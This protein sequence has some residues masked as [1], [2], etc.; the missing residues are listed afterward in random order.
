[1]LGNNDWIG[2][3]HQGASVAW[4][5]VIR[6][7]WTGDNSSGSLTLD[8]VSAGE[9]EV[10]AFFNNSYIVEASSQLRVG[11]ASVSTNKVNYQS[12]EKIYVH[13]ANMLGNQDWI[14]IYHQGA[15][16][17]WNNVIRWSWTGDTS[18]GDL[19]FRGLSSGNYEVRAFFNNSYEIEAKSNFTVVT[20]QFDSIR[21]LILDSK[22]GLVN[23]AT[24]IC[25]GDSTRAIS[26]HEGQ[27]LFFE[28]RDKLN[29]YN[30]NSIL[31]ARRGHRARQFL[32]QS[33][34]PT[35]SEVVANIPGDGDHAIVDISLGINDIWAYG[36]SPIKSDLK[37][38]ILN[39]KAQKPLTKFLLSMPN[40]FYFNQQDTNSIKAI[41]EE[42]S[43]ELNIPLNNVVQELMPTQEETQFSWYR[44]DGLGVHLSLSGQHLVAQFILGNILPIE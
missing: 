42:L 25:V 15:S 7:S 27:Y 40:R 24:Y 20:G 37:S 5:N 29:E 26:D 23:D 17:A 33:A 14:A 9:Y 30:V 21:E 3:Y 43:E 6:W 31:Q 32:D 28:I 4:N 19:V 18:S 44:D 22:Y 41:Y 12:T 39:I 34:S 13:F 36:P 38:A 8:G 35:W 2:L 1:M 16:V 11:S 10:R